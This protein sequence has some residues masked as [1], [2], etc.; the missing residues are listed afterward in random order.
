MGK[1]EGRGLPGEAGNWLFTALVEA[2]EVAGIGLVISVSEGD[3]V[4]VL[5][6]SGTV[7]AM[8]GH[9]PEELAHRPIWESLAPEELP[10]LL[11]LHQIRLAGHPVPA[12]FDTIALRKDG[13][14]VPV[15]IASSLVEIEGRP[16]NITFV[17]DA[18][19]RVAA[20][21]ALRSSEARFRL[22]FES[23][24]D[25]IAI[26]RHGRF[27]YVNPAAA[28]LLGFEHPAEVVGVEM[29]TVLHPEDAATAMRRIDALLG[30]Q[31]LRGEPTE[32]RR[33]RPGAADV[34]VEI[35]SIV[36]EWEG[37][38][39]ILGFARDVTERKSM[40]RRLLQ[41][42]RLAAL[43]TLA[44]GIAHEINNPLTYVLLNLEALRAHV[45]KAGLTPAQVVECERH[46]SDA[47]DGAERVKTI[48]R[49]LKG[50]ARVDDGGRARVDLRDSVAAAVKLADNEL[51]HRARLT[52]EAEEIPPVYA[53]ATRIEQVLV[54]LL[55]N[56][57]QAIEGDDHEAAE[58]CVR[59]R[60]AADDTVVVEV[61]DTG[62]GIP[63]ELVDRI[64]DPFF[65]TKPV[66]SGTGLGLPIVHSIITAHGGSVHVQSEVGK[67][68]TF[69][70][71]L[72]AAHRP[73]SARPLA[74]EMEEPATRR[75]RILV[76]DDERAVVETLRVYLADEHD[77]QVATTVDGAFEAIERDPGFDVVLCDVM[78]PGR[79][80]PA[81]Y[82]KLAERFPDVARRM[83]FMTG[84]AFA[85]DAA[86]FLDSV[87]NACLEKPF[88]LVVARSL[89]RRMVRDA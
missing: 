24:P 45:A 87:E 46:L 56:A 74:P 7:A 41:A 20:A 62:V 18:T 57:A 63:A 60:A 73:P 80:G 69:T 38:K 51:R 64:F 39:A 40:Q 86:D 10:R 26:S 76:V 35:S 68:S 66:G 25:G 36:I 50:F 28:A 65:T 4:E 9:E 2:A 14:R 31:S 59:V 3:R 88:D 79:G 61:S 12:R 1:H 44:A 71:V 47:L 11:E 23:A 22:L 83:V 27:L 81:L 67:G 30:G 13:T 17:M 52:V 85:R 34:V 15:E 70:V 75:G 49:D 5:H 82:R 43:G 37:E 53:N 78:M 72:P 6:A 19:A 89:L 33:T 84:G 48:V 29:R 55:I 54:N 8:L 32:Y 16:A 77:V 58:V 42:D 21:E